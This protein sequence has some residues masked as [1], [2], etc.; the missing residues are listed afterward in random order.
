V[1]S[2]QYYQPNHILVDFFFCG[3]RWGD[4]KIYM[5]VGMT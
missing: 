3:T 5:E 2:T 4:S 1:G